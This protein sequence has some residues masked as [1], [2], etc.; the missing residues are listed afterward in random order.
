MSV[1]RAILAIVLLALSAIYAYFAADHPRPSGYVAFA[2]LSF[3]FALFVML[4]GIIAMRAEQNRLLAEQN[5]LLQRSVRLQEAQLRMQKLE[6]TEQAPSQTTAQTDT[7]L[8]ESE[9]SDTAPPDV[10]KVTIRRG[11]RH[12]YVKPVR[13]KPET[14]ESAAHKERHERLIERLR[15]QRR[16]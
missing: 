7:P 6:R 13:P 9:V 14:P 5:A 4:S 11:E 2:V 3:G 12:V 8:S 16:D 15:R 1:L 10:S